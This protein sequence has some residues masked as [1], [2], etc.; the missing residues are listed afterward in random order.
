MATPHINEN[1]ADLL[2]PHFEDIYFMNFEEVAD[3]IAA[4]YSMPPHNGRADQRYS[5]VGDFGDWSQFMG[6]VNYQSLSQGFDSI[7]TFLE[8]CS[9]FQIERRLYDDEQYNIMDDMPAALGMAGA[10]TRQTHGAR[11]LNN[12]FSNDSFFSVHSEGVALCSTGH[13]SATGVST[14]SGFDNLTT[15]ALSATALTAARKQHVRLKSDAGNKIQIV[16]DEL[17]IP[18]DLYDVAYEIVASMGKVDTAENN[19][20]VH[21][22]AYTVH[23]WIY[24]DDANNWFLADGGLRKKSALWIDRIPVEFGMAEDFDTFVGK[25][26]GYMRYAPIWRDWRFILGGQ[27]S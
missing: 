5:Q 25:W 20:N 23:E 4:F 11:I 3:K 14:A 24:L 13:T 26:R 17:W 19:R 2:D 9:G 7:A 27:V 10:R 6:S 22:S 21:E 12:A 1:F 16:P 15:S 18:V 8:W